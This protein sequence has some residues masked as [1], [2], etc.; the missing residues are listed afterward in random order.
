[1]GSALPVGQ[2]HVLRRFRAMRARLRVQSASSTST[3]AAVTDAK[4]LPVVAAA[5]DTNGGVLDQS[6]KHARTGKPALDLESND[7]GTDRFSGQGAD[8][9]GEA[10]DPV[11]ESMR[12]LEQLCADTAGV[13]TAREQPRPPL[14]PPQPPL[15]RPSVRVGAVPVPAPAIA[16]AGTCV[17]MHVSMT[18]GGGSSHQVPIIAEVV[19]ASATR[20]HPHPRT[21]SAS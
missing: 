7:T 19:N 14:S 20:P 13:T 18:E 5:D 21:S 10:G 3:R 4:R 2:D 12:K 1:M 15:Q 16:G 8:N 17:D 6:K 9:E 11:V